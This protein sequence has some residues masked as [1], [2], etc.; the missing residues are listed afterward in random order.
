MTVFQT[1]GRAG[2]K[3]VERLERV[4]WCFTPSQPVRLYQGEWRQTDRKR[5]KE[6]EAETVE[7]ERETGERE[8]QR[9]IET[10]ERRKQRETRERQRETD[11]QTDRENGNGG[12]A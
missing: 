8:R 2:E 3:K 1:E 5:E 11:R 4:T 7:R 12:N 9:Q 6:T 10:G